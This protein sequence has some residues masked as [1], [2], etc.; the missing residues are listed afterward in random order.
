MQRTSELSRRRFLEVS[1]AAG[2]GLVL[3]FHLPAGRRAWLAAAEPPAN[4]EPNAFLRIAPDGTVALVVT[5]SE[6]GQGVRTALP[7]ILAEELGAD[8]TNVHVE[9]ADADSKYGDQDT[10][11]SS[12]V[13]ETWTPLRRAGAAAR[14]MLREAAS[15]T[16]GVPLERLEVRDGQVADRETGRSASFGELVQAAAELEPPAEP[17]L[18]SPADFRI[19]GTPRRRVDTPAI[20]R[21][22]ATYGID[23]RVPGMLHATVVHCPIFG[24]KLARFDAVETEKVPGVRKVVAVPQVGP[25]LPPGVAVIADS[26]WAAI[27]GARALAVEWDG[28]GNESHSSEGISATMRGLVGRASPVIRE[29]GDAE[30]ALARGGKIVSAEYELPFLAH[31][32]M[33]PMNTTAHVTAD[34]CEIWS[35]TQ[36]P[37]WAVPQVAG[38]L[39]IPPEKVKLH[40]TLL[41]GGFGRRINPDLPVE[42]A[43]VSRAAGAPVQVLWTRE[44]DLQHDFY[45]P[46][47]RHRLDAAL[48]EAGIP[49]AWRH[50]VASTS[51]SRYYRGPDSPEPER[52]ELGGIEDFPYTVANYRVE[53]SPVASPVPRG[54]WRSVEHLPNAFAIE[55]FLDE[56]A[57]AGGVDP[58]TLRL[59][60]LARRKLVPEPDQP[61]FP[62]DSDR[63]KR[64]IEVAAENAGWGGPLPAGR[65]RGLAAHRSF[66]SYVAEVAE[67]SLAADGK[68]KVDRVICAVDCGHVVNPHLV[69]RQ[70]ESGVMD[71][72]SATLGA[73][74]T[75]ENGAVR[76]R[77]FHEYRL[78]T[79]PDAPGSIEVHIVPSEAPPSGVGEPGLPPAAAAVTNA[80]F[81][82]TGGRVRRL[83]LRPED[84]R[85]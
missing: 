42:A 11:G 43:L 44:E 20:V 19:V 74:I 41:G 3:G 9:Q 21:G 16:L 50:R 64:V 69:E 51:I 10:G 30:G 47:S 80:L 36:F 14:E 18:R 78:L 40:V 83:P 1:A 67:V 37:G 52:N 49:I 71:A 68:V 26:T 70:I 12:S 27:A 54:W 76:Q 46:P 17:P 5:K 75:I 24:G 8:W 60:L 31:A 56:I 53:Y 23:V 48:D 22:E 58:L 62:L 39:G 25:I 7:M 6:M 79:M 28:G 82:L 13:R 77:N 45:R 65:A 73:E 55:S 63:L 84:L 4:W 66:L 34:G 29:D 38:A 2:T 59:R 72:L 15:R 35:P 81:A 61:D 33:E 32:T 57:A 85:T